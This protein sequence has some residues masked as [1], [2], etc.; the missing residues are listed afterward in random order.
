MVSR[1]LSAAQAGRGEG[2]TEDISLVEA[3]GGDDC[4]GSACETAGCGRDSRQEL[5]RH[6]Q[7]GLGGEVGHGCLGRS[8]RMEPSR[9]VVLSSRRQSTRTNRGG[10][11]S[12]VCAPLKN[13]VDVPVRLSAAATAAWAGGTGYGR[14]W[15]MQME[16]STKWLCS[17]SSTGAKL[18]ASHDLQ[19]SSRA[20]RGRWCGKR[21]A[22]RACKE[23]RRAV[24]L[25]VFVTDAR[26]LGNADGDRLSKLRLRHGSRAPPVHANFPFLFAPIF[27]SLEPHI[28]PPF[29]AMSLSPS[30]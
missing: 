8:R 3:V 5:T 29:E 12:R 14:R 19:E 15:M 17:T 1:G 26:W 24:L 23:R 11:Q 25:R 16:A 22:M 2:L 30:Q 6:A 20:R 21:Y 13:E 9:G 7:V 18:P 4:R 28:C 10:K 27:S